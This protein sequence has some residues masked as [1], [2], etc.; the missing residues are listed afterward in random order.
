MGAQGLGQEITKPIQ[1][2]RTKLFI[3][4]KSERKS[5]T[6]IYKSL[7]KK[8]KKFIYYNEK[9]YCNYIRVIAIVYA[10]CYNKI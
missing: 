5:K 8:N 3:Q 1:L 7:Q 10:K 6:S 4:K 9:N 2:E